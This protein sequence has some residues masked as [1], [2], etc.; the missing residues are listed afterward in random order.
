MPFVI[1]GGAGV[2]YRYFTSFTVELKRPLGMFRATNWQNT[3]RTSSTLFSMSFPTIAAHVAHA[4]GTVA[5]CNQ[6]AVTFPTMRWYLAHTWW[7]HARCHCATAI[8]IRTLQIRCS[9]FSQWSPNLQQFFQEDILRQLPKPSSW[10]RA[11]LSAARAADLVTSFVIV[12]MFLNALKAECVNARQNSGVIRRFETY[13]TF[14]YV[15][16]CPLNRN[17][18]S[19]KF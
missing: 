7:I 15:I 9:R 10:N 11:A 5:V 19:R 17:S 6:R 3:M 8:S 1:R 12:T 18:H 13:R 4:F 14:Q 2:T 16:N